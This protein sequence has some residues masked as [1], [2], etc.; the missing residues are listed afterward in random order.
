LEALA[1]VAVMN[2]QGRAFMQD[3]E[4]PFWT[5]RAEVERLRSAPG[6]FFVDNAC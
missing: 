1:L 2:L 4:N 6:L 5:A 3:L